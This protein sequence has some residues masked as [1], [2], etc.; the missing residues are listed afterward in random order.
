MST[1]A[2]V[3]FSARTRMGWS[4]GHAS[5][6]CIHTVRSSICSI[7][8]VALSS[9]MLSPTPS[10]ASAAVASALSMVAPMKSP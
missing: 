5:K 6:C 7:L 4:L 9:S 8:D 1:A 3:L 10:V 2:S